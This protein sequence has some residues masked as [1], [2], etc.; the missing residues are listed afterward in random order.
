MYTSRLN[1]DM[2]TAIRSLIFDKKQKV[3]LFSLV[4]L[5]RS[6]LYMNNR[7]SINNKKNYQSSINIFRFSF[8]FRYEIQP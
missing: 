8:S 3:P 4:K 5:D 1:L 6:Y 2:I 7:S